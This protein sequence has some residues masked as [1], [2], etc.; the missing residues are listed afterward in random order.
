MSN[1]QL[2]ERA[3]REQAQAVARALGISVE[4][5]DEQDWS[6]DE[7]VGNDDV[8]LGYVVT[9]GDGRIEHLPIWALDSTEPS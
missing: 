6:V 8:V 2:E 1:R 9:F 3:E 4:D 7:D 5:L